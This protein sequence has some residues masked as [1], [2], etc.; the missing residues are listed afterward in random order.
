VIQH[1]EI[2]VALVG[3]PNK[4]IYGGYSYL[5]VGWFGGGG[6][7]GGMVGELVSLMFRRGGK[8]GG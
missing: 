1:L 5:V 4:S 7:G 8:G 2:G 6:R 3:C